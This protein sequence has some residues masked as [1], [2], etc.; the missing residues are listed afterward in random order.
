MFVNYS[1]NWLITC[2]SCLNS[3]SMLL[4]LS[5]FHFLNVSRKLL[6]MHLIKSDYSVPSPKRS[7]NRYPSFWNERVTKGMVYWMPDKTLH[8]IVSQPKCISLQMLTEGCLCTHWFFCWWTTAWFFQM[9][10][11]DDIQKHHR[12]S[13]NMEWFAMLLHDWKGWLD[14]REDGKFILK[15]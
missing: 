10:L 14:H 5:F 11:I 4:K 12:V 6:N 1:S 13:P 15:N 9:I 2:K 8:R 7:P 3:L